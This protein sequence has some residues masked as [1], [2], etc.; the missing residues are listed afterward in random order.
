[1]IIG[2]CDRPRKG[3]KLRGIATIEGW[4]ISDTKLESIELYLDGKYLGQPIYGIERGD[5]HLHYPGIRQARKSGFRYFLRTT[6]FSSG[7]HLLEIKAYNQAQ[8]TISF[9][10]EVLI[11]NSSLSQV[12]ENR[13]RFFENC[14]QKR[15]ILDNL[16][17][18]LFIE[19]SRLC[20]V[21][22]IMC[23][24]TSYLDEL[25][26][27]GYSLG[28]MRWEVFERIVDLFPYVAHFRM[29]GW[30]EPYTN[31]R[32][33]EMISRI[34]RHNEEASISFNTNGLLLNEE[35][36]INLIENRVEQITISINSPYKENYEL[37]C[38]GGAFE[39]LTRNLEMI[40]SLKESYSSPYP[41]V[42]FEYVVMNQ[43]L[44]DMP[45]FV[46]FAARY[47]AS[48]IVFVN[49]G[50]VPSQ[51]E[52]LRLTQHGKFLDVFYKTKEYARELGIVLTGDAI[53]KFEVA[54]DRATSLDHPSIN[55]GKDNDFGI[56]CLAPFQLCY[57]S[58]DGNILPCPLINGQDYMGNLLEREFGEI[59]NS[60]SYVDMRGRFIEKGEG[61]M[62][63]RCQR[64]LQEDLF[65]GIC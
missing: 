47:G 24:S 30:G 15:T 17:L 55:P 1:M 9:Q 28:I 12:Q 59:W 37:I 29:A 26:N 19:P 64:C 49:L 18:Y 34:R 38:K 61:E 23:R 21:E 2:S 33:P 54:A 42:S 62:V 22:C 3:E 32:L 11:D 57:V 6:D 4:I 25:K 58:F 41:Q 65:M 27:A 35:R 40:I 53:S 60:G 44:F 52:H 43:N 20:N 31:F 51:M 50:L 5:V 39:R 8:E 16:P 48:S 10:G 13:L 7:Q 56:I 45:E 36:I 46:R 14:R 63:D